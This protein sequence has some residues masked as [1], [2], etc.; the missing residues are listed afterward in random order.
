MGRDHSIECPKCGTSYGGFNGPEHCLTC[1]GQALRAEYHERVKAMQSVGVKE[2]SRVVAERDKRRRLLARMAG[3]V[4]MGYAQRPNLLANE[5]ATAAVD[6]A[7][8]I[9][10]E[11][12]R[13]YPP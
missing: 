6:V 3:N 5:V 1:E 11:L 12:E 8:R 13:R 10:A 9:L 7:E 4:A 2:S